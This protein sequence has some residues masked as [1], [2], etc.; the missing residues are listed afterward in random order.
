M[1]INWNDNKSKISRFFTVGE[2]TQN[3]KRRIPLVG[4]VQE[5]RIITLAIQLDLIRLKWGK[6]ILVSSW[7]RPF[8]VNKEVGGAV[9][10]QHLMGSAVDVYP[11]SGSG[12]VFENFLDKEWGNRAL[13]YGQLAGRGFTHLD[14]RSG[15]LRWNY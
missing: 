10:S 12:I 4:S 14:L 8:A 11:S 7:Y 13:G 2:V 9:N 5:K 15:R 3:D 1:I 6:P